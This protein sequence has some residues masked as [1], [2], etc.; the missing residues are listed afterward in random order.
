MGDTYARVQE[1]TAIA[2]SKEI[3]EMLYEIESV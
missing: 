3:A 1:G 2:D